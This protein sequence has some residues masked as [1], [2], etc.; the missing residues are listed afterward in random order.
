MKHSRKLPST[1][2]VTM[3]ADRRITLYV[4]PV[5]RLPVTVTVSQGA[6]AVHGQCMSSTVQ[7]PSTGGTPVGQF[8]GAFTW[9]GRIKPKATSTRMLYAGTLGGS[10]EG[11]GWLSLRRPLTSRW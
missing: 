5:E 6:A 10:F 9:T 1:R 8:S 3:G 2:M 11:K 4:R 7:Q